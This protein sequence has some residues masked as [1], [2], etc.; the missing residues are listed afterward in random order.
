M[1]NNNQLYIFCGSFH[2]L[3]QHHLDIANHVEETYKTNVL[4][5]I[6]K[7]PFDKDELS[8]G[9]INNRLN[10]FRTICRDCLVTDNTSYM[11]RARYKYDLTNGGGTFQKRVFIVGFDTILRVDDPKYYFNSDSEKKRCIN[12]MK[13]TSRFLVFN[14]GDSDRSKLSKEILEICDFEDFK[15]NS[16]SST[17]LRNKNNVK[18]TDL[19]EDPYYKTTIENITFGKCFIYNNRLYKLIKDD[20]YYMMTA[21]NG[22]E[23]I[24]FR[25]GTVVYK[26]N[27]EAWKDVK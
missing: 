21:Y 10:Q 22:V 16:I 27:I 6:C 24:N 15:T 25:W 11:Q 8:E 26:T 12:Y 2:P 18:I 1:L 23:F 3:H 17:E 9:E 13:R 14:R 20:N 5:E 4:F 7:K 19:K